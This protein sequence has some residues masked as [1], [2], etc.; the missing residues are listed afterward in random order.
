MSRIIPELRHSHYP[1]RLRILKIT[2]LETRRVR[3]DLLDVFKIIYGLDSIFPTDFFIMENEHGK[4]RG[5]PYKISKLHC[6]L[7]I[8]KYSFNQRIANDWNILSRSAV[9]SASVNQF[10]GLTR[11]LHESAIDSF[12]RQLLDYVVEKDSR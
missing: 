9:M 6:R 1:S 10:K 11:G 4:T 12:P 7:D 2:T 5:H 3:A 8:R